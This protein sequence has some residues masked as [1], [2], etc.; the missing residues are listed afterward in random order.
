MSASKIGIINVI[1]KANSNKQGTK[2]VLSSSAPTTILCQPGKQGCSVSEVAWSAIMNRSD[3]VMMDKA[4]IELQLLS[5]ARI[6]QVLKISAKNIASNG[7]IKIVGSKGSSDIV[8]SSIMFR[9]FWLSIKSSGLSISDHRDRFYMYRLYRQLGIY[10]KFGTSGKQSVTHSLRHELFTGMDELQV[11]KE[12][13]AQKV[14]Q[15]S[16]NSQ[17]YYRPS[18]YGKAGK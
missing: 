10:G 8:I 14:G 5:G 1:N 16:M 17:N 9:S 18:M 4:I 7:V 6:S 15:K 13:A 11:S 3:L 2:A 12:V